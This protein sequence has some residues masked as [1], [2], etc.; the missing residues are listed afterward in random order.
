MPTIITSNNDIDSLA[1][2][3]G[4]RRIGDRIVLVI[5]HNRFRRAGV[6]HR[7]HDRDHLALLRPPVDEIA[8]E[9]HDAVR[10]AE[11]AFVIPGVAEFRQQAS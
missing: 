1:A 10:V 4:W 9:D 7:A 5:A 2:S 3:V 6:N 8:E 11:N